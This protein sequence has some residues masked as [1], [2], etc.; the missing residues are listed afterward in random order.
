MFHLMLNTVAL[1]GIVLDQLAL[2]LFRGH[3]S[4]ILPASLFQSC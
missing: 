1:A 2:E 4:R 3:S